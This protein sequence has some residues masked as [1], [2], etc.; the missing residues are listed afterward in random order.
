MQ[1]K[2]LKGEQERC[3][4]LEKEVKEFHVAN[5]PTHCKTQWEAMRT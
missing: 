5:L 4:S 1:H 3:D 2:E